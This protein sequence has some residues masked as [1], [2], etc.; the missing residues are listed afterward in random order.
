MSNI[1]FL[2]PSS[3]AA[4]TRNTYISQVSL[5]LSESNAPLSEVMT[6]FIVIGLI[7]LPLS[8]IAGMNIIS[9]FDFSQII[10]IM[11]CFNSIMLFYQKGWIGS[12]K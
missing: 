2:T 7:M 10:L 8:L 1:R 3:G 11:I 5:R 9:G 12:Q 4:S 6:T